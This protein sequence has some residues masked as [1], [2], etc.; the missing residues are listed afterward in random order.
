MLALLSSYSNLHLHAY[1]EFVHEKQELILM[2]T[3][4]CSNHYVSTAELRY[5]EVDG[6][7]KNTS[8]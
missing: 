7:Q 4:F 1:T 2:F 3:F 5:V 8:T 6:T